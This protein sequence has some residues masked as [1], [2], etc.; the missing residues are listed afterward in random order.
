MRS[1]FVTKRGEAGI[2]HPPALGDAAAYREGLL[3]V[4]AE[5]IYV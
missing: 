3:I 4:A 2:I 1:E 5:G